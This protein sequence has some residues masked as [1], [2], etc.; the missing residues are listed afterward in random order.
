[1]CAEAVPTPEQLLAR[2]RR[3]RGEP[4]CTLLELYR[5][6]LQLL[7][8]TQI[9]LHLKGL[10]DPSDL[11]QA[12]RWP[13]ASCPRP[14]SAGSSLETRINRWRLPWRLCLLFY[15][16]RRRIISANREQMVVPTDP[17]TPAS[18]SIRGLRLMDSGL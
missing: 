7:A 4:L 16:M 18:S 12:M 13:W 15:A 11:V 17:S 3:E 10:V 8:R 2:A 5:N 1:M 9:D 14:L 6:Y